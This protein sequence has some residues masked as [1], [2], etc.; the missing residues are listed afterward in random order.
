MEVSGDFGMFARPDTGSDST[1]YPIPTETA[2]LGMFQSVCRIKG[3]NLKIIG[4]AIC[5]DPKYMSFGYNASK[6]PLRKKNNK[7]KKLSLIMRHTILESPILQIIALIE[8][9]HDLTP[10][11][12][13]GV[14]CAHSFQSQFYRR[15]K[16]GQNFH[17]TS[18]G[19][20]EFVCNYVGLPKTNVNTSYNETIP[21]MVWF[22]FD[23]ESNVKTESKLN[24]KIRN[25][26]AQ[27]DENH[28]LCIDENGFI[29]FENQ[30]LK[31][32]LKNAE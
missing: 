20:K 17:Q 7:N 6:S 28:P 30:E 27:Y 19:W 21:S 16:R 32:M 9:N 29:N 26:I 23:K 10:Q 1:S 3:V 31:E 24:F 5:N 4:S 15:L 11:K 13:K 12:Y 18:L 8:N 22:I 25:G 2:C 14:N